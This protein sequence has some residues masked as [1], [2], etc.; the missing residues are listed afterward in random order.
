TVAQ[1]LPDDVAVDAAALVLVVVPALAELSPDV[2]EDDRDGGDPGIRVGHPRA[3]RSVA[4][5]DEDVADAEVTL[6]VPQAIAVHPQDLL[7]LLL[8]HRRRGVAVLRALD[9]QL[10]GSARGDAVVQPDALAEEVGLD[11]E[12]RVDLRDHPHRPSRPVRR[13]AVLAVGVDLG[14]GERLVARTERTLP[15]A[16][17]RRRVGAD[18][19]PAPAG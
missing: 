10:G 19:N 18:E 8:P 4:L 11:A 14:R 2:V 15:G 9:D 13:R 1:L 5:R 7:P 6:E 12:V 3:G 17:G 16:V